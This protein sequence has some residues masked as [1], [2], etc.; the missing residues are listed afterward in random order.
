[1]THIDDK[2][3]DEFDEFEDADFENDDFSDMDENAFDDFDETQKGSLKDVWQNNP[4]VKLGVIG[5]GL[6]VIIV[7]IMLFSGG[8]ENPNSSLKRTSGDKELASTSELNP[9]M[10]DRI[11][12]VNE[13]GGR[14][15]EATNDSFIPLSTNTFQNPEDYE[16]E[17]EALKI[18]DPLD[19]FR[20][21]TRVQ[22]ERVP[23]EPEIMPEQPALVPAPQPQLP[24]AAPNQQMAQA[25]SNGL[26]AQMRQIL[27]GQRINSIRYLRVTEPGYV[28][29][30]SRAAQLA[31]AQQNAASAANAANTLPTLEDIFLPAG[32][33]Y[34]AQTLTEANTDSPGPVLAQILQGPLKGSRIIGAF[35]ETEDYLTIDFDRA[36]YKDRTISISAIALD[37]NTTLPGVVTEIDN[38]YFKRV[39]LPAAAAFVEGFGSAVA[40]T[41]NTSVSVEGETVTTSENDLNTREELLKGVEESTSIISEFLQEEADRT[42]VM[43]KVAAGTPIGVLFLEE[44]TQSQADG[45]PSTTAQ[46]PPAQTNTVQ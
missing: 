35:S 41:G 32:E 3:N 10:K 30:R 17:Q 43:I 22:E 33:V 23:K 7:A 28:D 12:E 21:N 14:V 39:I 45:F 26:A 11:D 46:T 34:Y 5:L 36:V 9:E 8:E 42:Q 18:E 16:K 1:M 13:F 20:T 27:E 24:P 6:V 31:Q 38:R 15:A 25:L 37:E 19:Q 2:N 4:M 29:P 40:E 44:I